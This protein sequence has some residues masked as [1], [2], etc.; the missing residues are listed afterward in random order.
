MHKKIINVLK[1][2]FKKNDT[3]NINIDEL[4]KADYCIDKEDE[5]FSKAT[6]NEVKDETLTTSQQNLD[7]TLNQLKILKKLA[8]GSNVQLN[9]KKELQLS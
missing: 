5:L 8:N 7:A 2:F 9:Q 3:E 1:N 6:E 4:T